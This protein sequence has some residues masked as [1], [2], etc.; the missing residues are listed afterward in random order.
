MEISG[1][2]YYSDT[3]KSEKIESGSFFTDDVD[4]IIP[5]P[6][7]DA[8][9]FEEKSNFDAKVT[10]YFIYRDNK[11]ANLNSFIERRSNYL[12]SLQFLD[13]WISGNSTSPNNGVIEASKAVLRSFKN[14]A[15]VNPQIKIPNIVMGPMPTGGVTVEFRPSDKNTLF[16]TLYNDSNIEIDIMIDDAFYSIDK[17]DANAKP[18]I[19]EAY[20]RVMNE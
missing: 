6:S 1:L 20:E 14:W 16:I 7:E 18:Y 9:D 13:N 8:S 12:E 5:I 19:I 17:V 4:D 2:D 10:S 11:L 3:E 15:S